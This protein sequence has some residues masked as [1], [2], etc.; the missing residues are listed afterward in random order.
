MIKPLHLSFLS[1]AISVLTLGGAFAAQ[2]FYWGIVVA[3]TVGLS[4]MLLARSWIYGN[5]ISMLVMILGISLEA[6]F[7][8]ARLFLLISLLAALSAWDL[9]GFH[10]CL[11][12]SENLSQEETLIRTH[13][14]RLG[15]VLILGLALPLISFAMQ[16]K[17]EFWQVFLLG[18][19][20]LVGLSQA[21]RQLK[22]NT[23]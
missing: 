7:G 23:P 5:T 17:L 21:F 19:T 9:A 10:K 13:L 18:M 1:I 11:A 3:V 16:F 15:S 2:G 20:L 6:M 12:A 8:G 4:W 14:A 22:R